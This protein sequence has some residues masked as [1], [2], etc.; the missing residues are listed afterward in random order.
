MKANKRIFFICFLFLLSGVTTP[1]IS[2]TLTPPRFYTGVELNNKNIFFRDDGGYAGFF[3]GTELFSVSFIAPEIEVKYLTGN[4]EYEE[5]DVEGIISGQ[6]NHAMPSKSITSGEFDSWTYSI[7]PKLAFGDEDFRFLI[8]PKYSIASTSVR[9]SYH[10]IDDAREYYSRVE[11]DEK[12]ERQSYFTFG[13]GAEGH[14]FDTDKLSFALTLHY[15]AW[16]IR[17]LFD[18]LNVKGLRGEEGKGAIGIGFRV[19]FNPFARL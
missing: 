1:I 10:V 2:Q 9:A 3:V 16:N 11:Q 8:L 7:T 5:A 13:I 17:E 15:S 19:Y 4:I 6:L 14:I 12:K 18:G